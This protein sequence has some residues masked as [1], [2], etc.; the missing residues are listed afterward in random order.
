[1]AADEPLESRARA[2]IT[3][4]WRGDFDGLVALAGELRAA[5][6][7]GWVAAMETQAW[8]AGAGGR[9]ADEGVAVARGEGAVQ[10]CVQGQRVALLALEGSDVGRWAERAQAA[11][12]DAAD[13]WVAAA[14]CWAELV[15][16]RTGAIAELGSVAAESARARD[17]APLAIEAVVLRA[18]AALL[19]ED[20]E[21]ATTL[22]RRASRMA[23][24]E[25]LPQQEYLANVVLA[26]VRRLRG[27]A[28]LATRILTALLE[29]ASEPWRPWMAWELVLASG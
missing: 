21:E 24:T 9:V 26:R 1:M 20:L 10:A 17:D 7:K 11:A 12:V 27:N 5:G 19:D 28:P 18:I 3:R 6:E 2:Q 15:D 25:S 23:R 4:G 22:A 14:R 29:V 16:G 13:G 8:L